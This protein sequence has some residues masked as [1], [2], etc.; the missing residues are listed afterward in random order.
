[1][2]VETGSHVVPLPILVVVTHTG[3]LAA[4]EHHCVVDVVTMREVLHTPENEPVVAHLVDVFH[5]TIDPSDRSVE[6]RLSAG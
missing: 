1:M 6:D 3:R 5:K 4:E 2:R